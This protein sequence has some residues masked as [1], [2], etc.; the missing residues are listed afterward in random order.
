MLGVQ[1]LSLT[2]DQNSGMLWEV[3]RFIEFRIA[4]SDSGIPGSGIWN[5]MICV[6]NG[7][8]D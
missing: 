6:Y 5:S 2:Q 4:D 3:R 1:T 7:V 8:N